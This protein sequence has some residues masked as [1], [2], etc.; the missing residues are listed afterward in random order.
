MNISI[1]YQTGHTL[2][3]SLG[4]PPWRTPYGGSFNCST[5]KTPES[6]V[7]RTALLLLLYL[8]GEFAQEFSKPSV[9]E[10]ALSEWAINGDGC[11]VL[12]TSQLNCPVPAQKKTGGG[13]WYTLGGN[14]STQ[15]NAS[16]QWQLWTGSKWRPPSCSQTAHE[17]EAFSIYIVQ[18]Q[19]C[20][21]LARIEREVY[22][23]DTLFPKM[24]C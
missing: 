16:L 15:H 23:R 10:S 14:N 9:T 12:H 17:T 18:T 21:H 1:S 2:R 11:F 8:G 22:G 4:L 7:M 20:T 6:S 13:T 24:I 19:S 3:S 5:A